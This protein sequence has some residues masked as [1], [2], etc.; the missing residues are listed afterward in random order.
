MVGSS[1]T[2]RAGR[3]GTAISLVSGLDIGNFRTMQNVNRMV[4]PE[5]PIPNGTRAG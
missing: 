4:I 1:R 5:R 3:T 2:G